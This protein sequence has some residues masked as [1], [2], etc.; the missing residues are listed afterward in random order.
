MQDEDTH[1]TSE[2]IAA[3]RVFVCGNYQLVEETKEKVGRIYLYQ[4]T[5]VEDEN[6]DP[7]RTQLEAKYNSQASSSAS[8][9]QTS[10]SDPTPVNLA[11]A[12]ASSSSSSSSLVDTITLSS[13]SHPLLTHATLETSAIF[14]LKWAPRVVQGEKRLL[15]EVNAAGQ[16]KMYEYVPP[17]MHAGESQPATLTELYEQQVVDRA[18]CLSLDWN[19]RKHAVA[20]PQIAVSQS[21][22][23]ISLWQLSQTGLQEQARWVAHEYEMW[24]V[25]YNSHTPH[26]L[27]SGADDT[28]FKGWDVR[29][30][31]TPRTA[32]FIDST[33]TMGVCSIQSHPTREHFLATGSYDENL[34][35]WDTRQ[36]RTPTLVHPLGGGVW[37][38]RWNPSTLP[39]RSDS[40]LCCAMHNGF[41]VVDLDFATAVPTEIDLSA[42]AHSRRPS[43]TSASAVPRR[44]SIITTSMSAWTI[45]AYKEHTSLAYGAD[46]CAEP[47]QPP[48]VKK[49]SSSSSS[50]SIASASKLPLDVIATCSFYDKQLN[51][52]T[53]ER[54]PKPEI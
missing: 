21:N 4:M 34:R 35:I 53:M 5:T 29:V 27:Y 49:A 33:H 42:P 50:S 16:L 45:A 52:W 15:G 44:N 7:E 47:L 11:P 43:A 48:P 26:I 51:V 18:S 8:T 30:A 38:V 54:F 10:A 17:T 23:A 46:W 39:D 12:A 31:N 41:A 36:M 6:R 19:N 40:V 1:L 13:P 20:E 22:S 3:R 24:I 32:I 25:S 37:R 2:D 14:D 9:P 28:K